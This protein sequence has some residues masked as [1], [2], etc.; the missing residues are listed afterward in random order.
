TDQMQGPQRRRWIAGAAQGFSIDG[1]VRH[2]QGIAHRLHP[3]SETT[4]KHPWIDLVENPLQ[5]IMR[6]NAMAKAQEA[7]EPRSA[8]LGKD[9]DILPVITIRNHSTDTD[10]NNIKKPMS[11]PPPNSAIPEL[12]EVFLNRHSAG[13]GH[14]HLL[15][16]G[17]WG[18]PRENRRLYT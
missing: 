3:T 8:F 17:N 11:S 13:T 9:L 15:F 18:E 2:A 12:S 14:S 10:H 7:L 4:G 6:R 16:R 1:N 5:G